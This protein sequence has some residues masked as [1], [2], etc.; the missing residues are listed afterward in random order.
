MDK[1]ELTFANWCNDTMG[2]N[3]VL[4]V[5]ST[6]QVIYKCWQRESCVTEMNK[7]EKHNDLAGHQLGRYRIEHRDNIKIIR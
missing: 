1:I 6:K 2:Y 5:E 7:C 3:W 4:Y